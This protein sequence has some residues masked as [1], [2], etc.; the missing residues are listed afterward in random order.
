MDGTYITLG[1][2][3]KMEMGFVSHRYQ[4]SI[5]KL[6]SV[7]NGTNGSVQYAREM[8][9]VN[10]KNI[11]Q[12]FVLCVFSLFTEVL[13]YHPYVRGLLQCPFTA[14]ETNIDLTFITAYKVET[15]SSSTDWVVRSL[16]ATAPKDI[17]IPVPQSCWK[18]SRNTSAN[19]G[20]SV[21]LVINEVTYETPIDIMAWPV[22]NT[23]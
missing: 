18:S 5:L 16:E 20:F 23:P 4:H 7:R 10:E 15:W 17:E 12:P 1:R 19:N 22:V 9:W 8:V 11:P 3:S 6:R 13:V 14:P 21:P 2:E